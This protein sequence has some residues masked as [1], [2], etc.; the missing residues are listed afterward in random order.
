MHQFMPWKIVM[1]I[2]RVKKKK[3][4]EKKKAFNKERFYTD[5][6][7]KWRALGW[8]YRWPNKYNR[9]SQETFADPREDLFKHVSTSKHI[10]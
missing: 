5:G 8:L 3:K 1:V 2:L 6:P 4:W 9:N 10:L 7:G